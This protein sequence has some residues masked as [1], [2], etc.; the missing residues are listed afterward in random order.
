MNKI[1]IAI[2]R[3][4]EVVAD[5][6]SVIDDLKKPLRME[7]DAPLCEACW[8]LIGAYKDALDAKYAIGGWLEWWWLDCDLGDKP[9]FATPSG[10]VRRDIATIDDLVQLI[11]EDLEAA[12]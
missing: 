12:S 9:R 6:E 11:L 5:M 1:G 2:R 4:H 10:G 7:P 3:F 8:H